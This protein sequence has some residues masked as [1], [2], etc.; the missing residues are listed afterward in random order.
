MQFPN[1][2]NSSFNTIN[3]IIK[4]LGV[5]NNNETLELLD[6]I[7]KEGNY[8]KIV[9][10]VM[11]GMGNN[12]INKYIKDDFLGRKNLGPISTVFPS[13]T[14][15]SMNTYYSA[16]TPKEHAWLGWST[17]FKECSRTINLFPGTDKYSNDNISGK[18]SYNIDSSTLSDW[19]GK[20]KKCIYSHP[21]FNIFVSI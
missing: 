2:S 5:K 18:I 13:T 7:L 12:L 14:T 15:A 20:N 21:I 10:M 19:N 8:K 4:F 3:S 9:F 17:Y 1:Y 11:D 6:N 16:K